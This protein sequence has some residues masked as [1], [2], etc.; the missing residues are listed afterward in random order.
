MPTWESD[1]TESTEIASHNLCADPTGPWDGLRWQEHC[2]KTGVLLHTSRCVT[3][4]IIHCSSFHEGF[5][6]DSAYSVL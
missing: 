5:Y 4:S 3:G 6:I 1:P 2:K